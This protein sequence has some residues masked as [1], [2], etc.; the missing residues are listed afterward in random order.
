MGQRKYDD[1]FL[2]M[3][4]ARIAKGKDTAEPLVSSGNLKKRFLAG[5]YKITGSQKYGSARFTF[6]N[7]PKTAT[8]R[9]TRTGLM[10]INIPEALVEITDQEAS[11]LS[12]IFD[13]LLQ[14]ELTKVDHKST[15]GRRVF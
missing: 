14:D 12:N 1:K 4:A 2:S 10:N 6:T 13:R 15:H 5:S 9:K 8:K 11:E 7:L 3:L